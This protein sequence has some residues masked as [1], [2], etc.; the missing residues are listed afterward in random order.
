MKNNIVLELEIINIEDVLKHRDDLIKYLNNFVGANFN[1]KIETIKVEF[2]DKLYFIIED[3]KHLRSWLEGRCYIYLSKNNIKH[4]ILKPKSLMEFTYGG[5]I[6]D[7]GKLYSLTNNSHNVILRTLENLR[8]HLFLNGI[9]LT[10]QFNFI[11]TK[12]FILGESNAVIRLERVL[13]YFLTKP[14]SKGFDKELWQLLNDLE[15]NRKVKILGLTNN[16]VIDLLKMEYFETKDIN[17]A[18]E[19]AIFKRFNKTL[20]LIYLNEYQ[21]LDYFDSKS[22]I[23][24]QNKSSL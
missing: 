6:L 11:L 5:F 15:L 13:K 9:S 22:L 1:F 4:K 20:E 3:V 2:R 16:T 21:N 10:E 19:S 18:N 12:I 17:S 24:L 8:S 23:L 14:N 7:N